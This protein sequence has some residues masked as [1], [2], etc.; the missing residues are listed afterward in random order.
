M[1]TSWW[2]RALKA[3]SRAAAHRVRVIWTAGTGQSNFQ[4]L[5]LTVT[6]A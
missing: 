5:T 1:N 3:K 2:K 4:E 6:K